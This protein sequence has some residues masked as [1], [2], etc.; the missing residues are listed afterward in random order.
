MRDN[1]NDFD[2]KEEDNSMSAAGYATLNMNIINT[3]KSK[4]ISS[5][6]ALKDVTPIIWDNEVLNGNKK[7]IITKANNEE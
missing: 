2:K 4:I 5:K 1:K 3:K 7:V 6:E